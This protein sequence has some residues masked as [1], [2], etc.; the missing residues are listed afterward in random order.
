MFPRHSCQAR[1]T[2]SR[3]IK[4]HDANRF[5]WYS[6][7]LVSLELQIMLVPVT[8][9]AGKRL[10]DGIPRSLT[11]RRDKS[12]QFSNGNVFISYKPA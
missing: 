2:I 1:F 12:R 6:I 9:G 7:G 10:F 11:W 4:R 5:A 8:L 3:G